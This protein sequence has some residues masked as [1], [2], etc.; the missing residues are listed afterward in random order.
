ME[1]LTAAFHFVAALPQI[2]T[3]TYEDIVSDQFPSDEA[4]FR[5]RD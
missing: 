4:Q 2:N 1:G 3:E 5:V